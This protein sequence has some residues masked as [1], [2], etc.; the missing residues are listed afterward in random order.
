MWHNI[1][2]AG[3]HGGLSP[4]APACCLDLYD[5]RS[6]IHFQ[7]YFGSLFV[8]PS[9][10]RS[11]RDYFFLVP[12][13]RAKSSMVIWPRAWGFL[14]F[15]CQTNWV[16]AWERLKW[17]S[18]AYSSRRSRVSLETE[19][20]VRLVISTP[21]VESVTMRLRNTMWLNCVSRGKHVHGRYRQEA[22]SRIDGTWHVDIV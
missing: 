10:K 13:E 7:L 2:Q 1:Q 18:F 5:F 6:F 11:G 3:A 20:F 17:F 12:V 8:G 21:F 14:T 19:M 4:I 15:A 22:H 16:I 9:S